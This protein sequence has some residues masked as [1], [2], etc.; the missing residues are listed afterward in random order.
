MAVGNFFIAQTPS[1]PVICFWSYG[2]LVGVN[3]AVKHKEINV[4]TLTTM[5]VTAVSVPQ[6]MLMH[7]AE[8]IEKELFEFPNLIQFPAELHEMILSQMAAK[9]QAARI[10]AAAYAQVK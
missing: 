3:R 1:V 10:I 2:F 5:Q 8:R 6:V 7:M 9:I 4:Y